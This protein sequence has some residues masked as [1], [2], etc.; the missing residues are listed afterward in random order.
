MTIIPSFRRFIY[1]FLFVMPI[2]FNGPVSDAAPP[3]VTVTEIL[4]RTFKRVPGDKSGDAA[5]YPDQRHLWCNHSVGTPTVDF[6]GRTWRMWFVGM[7]MTDN[8]EIPYGFA[9]RLGLA[10]SND[11][12]HWNIANEG[13]P[14]LDFGSP[15]KFDDAG[16]SH[17]FVLR[18]DDRYMMWYGGIDGR[19]G[20]D[21]GVGPAHVRVEQI[22]LATSRDGVS[23]HRENNGN[24]VLSIGTQDSI[25]AVQV[26]G[27]HVIRK[28]NRFVMWYGAY[29][30]THTIGLATSSDGVRWN[31]ENEGRSLP[32]L[33]GGKQLG[34]SVYFDGN[35]YLMFYN[36][37]RPTPN[38]GSQWTLYSA[39]SSDGIKWQPANH[40][41]PLLDEAPEGNFGSADGQAG[42]N[43][44]VHPTKMIFIEDAIRM[45]YG[46]EEKKPSPGRRYPAGAIGLMELRI[47]R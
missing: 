5:I 3:S 15:G 6:D 41:K 31:K 28:D 46:A 29:N 4:Q 43:H 10:T 12:I 19:T 20:K 7:S 18:V 14:I 22:G 34:P 47:R 11:G 8:P 13:Q 36:T 21:V 16:L 38:G 30:G 33:M 26:T 44:A 17:P 24:P 2:V 1:V 23:W 32:G 45:G 42:N 37:T 40:N 9:A 39:T 27:C 35:Q 25:D